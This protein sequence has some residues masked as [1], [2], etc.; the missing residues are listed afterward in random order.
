MIATFL[1]GLVTG[2]M[3]ALPRLFVIGAP[4]LALVIAVAAFVDARMPGRADR[5]QAR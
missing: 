3:Q 2:L 4:I 5:A 1:D